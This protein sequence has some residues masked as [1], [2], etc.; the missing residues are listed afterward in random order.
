LGR[1]QGC[2]NTNSL[3]ELVL[4][5]ETVEV[6]SGVIALWDDRIASV[7]RL[8]SRVPMRKGQVRSL[9]TTNREEGHPFV[10]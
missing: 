6:S 8:V 7:E 1:P 5:S 9:A 10:L 2:K 4:E 3:R